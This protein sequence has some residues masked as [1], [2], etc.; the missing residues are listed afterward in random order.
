MSFL[1]LAAEAFCWSI[2]QAALMSTRQTKAKK[3]I[4]THSMLEKRKDVRVREART[5]VEKT[6]AIVLDTRLVKKPC[7]SSFFCG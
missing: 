1:F 3:T 4:K 7:A 6:N 5:Y 2:S